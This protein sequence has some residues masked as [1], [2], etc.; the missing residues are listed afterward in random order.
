MSVQTIVWAEVNVT[1]STSW[2]QIE[3]VNS[4]GQYAASGSYYLESPHTYSSTT[5][6]PTNTIVIGYQGTVTV[7]K[8]NTAGFSYSGLLSA[9]FGMSG[10]SSST[11]YARKYYPSTVSISLR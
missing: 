8:G 7:A 4:A 6:F 3:R 9:G 2:G 11:W 5:R 10:S 1:A